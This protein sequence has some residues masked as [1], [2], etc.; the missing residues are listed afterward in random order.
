MNAIIRRSLHPRFPALHRN[1]AVESKKP[2]QAPP[3]APESKKAVT[4][5]NLLLGTFTLLMGF[6][7]LKP[8]DGGS[9]LDQVD[10][11]GNVEKATVKK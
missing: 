4:L 3:F 7:Y 8:W 10:E 9:I 2:Y 6:V 5:R 1:F 11:D